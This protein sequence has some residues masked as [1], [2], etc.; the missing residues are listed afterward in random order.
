[1]SDPCREGFTCCNGVPML[2]VELSEVSEDVCAYLCGQCGVTRHALPW[3]DAR[4]AKVDALLPLVW[5]AHL[6]SRGDVA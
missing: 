6:D 5:Q 4:R 2:H 1:M 3:G